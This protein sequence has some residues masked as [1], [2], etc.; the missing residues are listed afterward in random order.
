MRNLY[1]K[2]AQFKEILQ[3]NDISFNVFIQ[4]A[5]ADNESKTLNIKDYSLTCD[6]S[7]ASI[8]YRN[9][10]RLVLN[11]LGYIEYDI[12]TGQKLFKINTK[13]IE[14]LKLVDNLLTQD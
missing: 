14:L 4:L 12:K 5:A 13:G 7:K 1:E 2:L 10:N 3:Q 9:F 8:V 6:K 11:N